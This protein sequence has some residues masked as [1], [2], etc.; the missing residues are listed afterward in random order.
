MTRFVE[1]AHPRAHTGVFVDKAQSA[2]Q[3]ALT[4]E[5]SGRSAEVI[6]QG[7]SEWSAGDS[8]VRA[9]IY[10]PDAFLSTEV[11]AERARAFI[12]EAVFAG[13]LDA[14]IGYAVETTHDGV[15][16]QQHLLITAEVPMARSAEFASNRG[17]LTDEGK[18]LASKL[19]RIGD[20][21]NWQKSEPFAPENS[22]YRTRVSI[23]VDDPDDPRR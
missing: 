17:L 23:D 1:T 6:P 9:G 22:M 3:I 4:Q 19:Q 8:V 5:S 10:Y 13:E 18:Q 21:W 7:M 20:G 2:P 16:G 15:Y 11:V 14:G 12:N